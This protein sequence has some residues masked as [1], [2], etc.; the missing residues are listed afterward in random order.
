MIK[1]TLGSFL[2]PFWD[3]HHRSILK[4]SSQTNVFTVFSRITDFEFCIF[5]STAPATQNY[6][7]SYYHNFTQLLASNIPYTIT[8]L[9]TAIKHIRYLI[10]EVILNLVWL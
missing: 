4:I 2:D 5:I 9:L 10:F 8:P 3:C 6:F 1:F 7:A